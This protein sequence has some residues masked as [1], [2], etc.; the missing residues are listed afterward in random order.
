VELD[1]G[2]KIL[3]FLTHSLMNDDIRRASMGSIIAFWKSE[4]KFGTEYLT[5]CVM[6]VR[7]LMLVEIGE[8]GKVGCSKV[9]TT[10]SK[11]FI[12]TLISV[13][14]PNEPVELPGALR[15]DGNLWH[16]SEVKN[17]SIP[18][19]VDKWYDI[20]V[21]NTGKSLGLPLILPGRARAYKTGDDSEELS[22]YGLK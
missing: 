2:R 20:V 5:S 12:D 8:D 14:S 17:Y 10:F 15:G 22:V 16:G 18:E 6:S 3:V 11:G 1:S 7:Y 19:W 4:F 21:G 13:F 9:F